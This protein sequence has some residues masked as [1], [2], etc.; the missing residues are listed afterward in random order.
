MKLL[1][2]TSE[3]KPLVKTGGLGDVSASLPV[4]LRRLRQDARLI[5]PAYRSAKDKVG[6][7]RHVADLSLPGAPEPV[8]ILEGLLPGSRLPVYLV[9]SPTHF[10]RVGDPYRASDGRDWQDNAARFGLFCRAVS[11]I[12]LG[13]SELGWQPQIVH[14]NDWQTGLVPALLAPHTQRPATVFTIHNLA[15][16]GLFPPATLQELALPASLWAADGLEFWGNLSFIKG[17]LG[18]A[19]RLTTVSPTY[20]EE[21]QTPAFGCGLDGLLRYRSDVLTGILNGIDVRE[22]DPSRDTRIARRYAAGTLEVKGANKQ[23][24]QRR[25]GLEERPELPLLGHIGRLVSQKGA[26][27]ILSAAPSFLAKERAQLAVLGSGDPQLEAG[28]RALAGSHPGRC[29]V[30]IGY[31]EELAH[32]IEAGADVFLMPSRFEPCGL[33]QMYSLRYGTPPIARRTGGLADTIIDTDAESLR[34]G[35][36]TGFLFDEAS[37]EALAE[38][39]EWALV[40]FR[41]PP[42]WETLQQ[43]GMAID[44][45]WERSA[46]SYL[47]LYRE[48]VAERE[49]PETAATP[50]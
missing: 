24:L 36:A 38:A 11:A 1:F 27:L 26:D 13:E 32:L 30:H 5:M 3:A 48:A 15:Y 23:V 42:M 43:R 46:R 14:C 35:T 28:L 44:F 7:T 41:D 17:G 49:H 47:E 6:A 39:I 16:Q 37:S 29:G 45:S 2:A 34:A 4:A 8:R 10:D 40:L 20:A 25:L 18:F 33:N 19:D 12:A 50:V 31:D 9:D 22:W 21:I